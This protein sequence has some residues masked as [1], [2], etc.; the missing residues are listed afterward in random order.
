M[1]NISIYSAIGGLAVGFAFCY[2]IMSIRLKTAKQ[3][4]EDIIESAHKAADREKH[5]IILQAKEEWFK[6]RDQ[7][8]EEIKGKIQQLDEAEGRLNERIKDFNRKDDALKQR[9]SVVTKKSQEIASQRDA[10]RSKEQ[11]LLRIIT[12]Q[13]E[14]L[15]R[16]TSYSIAEAKEKLLENLQREYKQEAA[17]L[18]KTLIDDAKAGAQREAKK[19]VTY[20]IENS[21]AEYAA[22]MAVS[23]IALPSEDVKGRIIGKDGR[24]IKSFEQLSGVKL[25]VDDTPEA[26]VLSCFDP[27]KREVARVALEKLIGNGKIHPQ[28]IEDLLAQAETE[29]EK[30][31]WRAGNE[32]V[33]A[34]GIGKIHPDL[35][36]VL[37]RLYYRTSYGQNVLMH[38][39]EVALLC[40]AMA[41]ELDLDTKIAR[42]AGLLHDI[43]KAISQSQ[44]GTHTELGYNLCMQYNENPHVLN[45][46]VSHHE[47]VPADNLYSVLVA[48]A[49]GIS[50]SRPGA[51]RD[52][53]EGYVQRIESLEE[54]ADSFDGVEKS[55]AISAGREVRVMVQ[56]EAITDAQADLLSRDIAQKI[57]QELNY[58]GQVKITVIRET[59][60]VAYA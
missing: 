3:T 24:N 29:V 14:E 42:R 31:I 40:G 60:A 12:K 41:A 6:V 47:D 20:A 27:V 59:K 56:P 7:Q 21:A 48:A 17:E 5:Q 35:I 16:V 4:A 10:L 32:V 39:K 19:I 2:F 9:E 28:R 46:I 57:Q 36:R 33:A 53:L 50:G 55:F 26:V 1:D 45:A 49:D 8:Q 15:S 34:V 51:R 22:E 52:T 38:S 37:G 44:E 54:L 13:N 30:N 23:V 43:G 11:E 18:Y 25:I 58:P